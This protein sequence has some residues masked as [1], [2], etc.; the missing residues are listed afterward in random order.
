VCRNDGV[1]AHAQYSPSASHYWKVELRFW[2]TAQRHLVVTSQNRRLRQQAARCDENTVTGCRINPE[3]HIR[4]QDFGA[5]VEAPPTQDKQ[6]LDKGG[7]L[8]HWDTA[9]SLL[10]FGSN[11]SRGIT[12]GRDGNGNA[13]VTGDNSNV[14]VVIYQSVVIQR[15]KKEEHLSDSIEPNPYT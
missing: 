8:Q 2:Q 3:N 4:D 1:E 9:H 13:F 14:R 6:V 10:T 12:V 5:S 15:D 11:G 7:W